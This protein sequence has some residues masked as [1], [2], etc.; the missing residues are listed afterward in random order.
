VPDCGTRE[1]KTF[2]ATE[3]DAAERAAYRRAFCALVT[4]TSADRL[5]FIDESGC[6]TG[7]RR[8]Y[9]WSARGLRVAGARPGRT[10]RT[11]SLIGAIR[12][13]DRP[14]L[15]T[16]RGAV[17]GRIFLNFV[18]F[19]LVRSL[20]KGD[21]VVMD[22]PNFHKSLV[23]RQAIEAAGAAPLYLPTYSPELNPIELW[24]GDMKR[25]LRTLAIDAHAAGRAWAVAR[26]PG[27]PLPRS[28]AS[29]TRSGRPSTRV[30]F[31]AAIAFRPAS[32]EAIVTNANPRDWPVSRSEMIR[33]SVTSP[34]SVKAARSVSA[35][36]WN[37]RL[38]TYRRIASPGA[39][40]G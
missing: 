23:V 3:R 1:K 6:K 2:V 19:H 13:G 36:Q 25:Q 15:M 5:V 34:T 18:R 33:T 14:R 32:G 10:W 37:A 12:L 27:P 40:R 30:P 7:M 38:P 9:G 29:F 20:R 16:H 22:N 21:I 35:L 39:R 11:L 24:W 4:G 28:S 8:E 31:S 26:A 17:N